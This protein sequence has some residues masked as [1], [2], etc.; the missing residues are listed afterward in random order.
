VRR[1]VVLAATGALLFGGAA[2]L[3]SPAVAATPGDQVVDAVMNGARE[4][5]PDGRRNGGDPDGRGSFTAIVSGSQLCFGITVEKLGTPVAA[6]VHKA[7]P[8]APGPVV[9]PLVAP[10]SGDPGTSSGCVTADPA[11]LANIIAHPHQYYVNVH[12]SEYPA[13]AVRGQLFHP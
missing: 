6:H 10:S 3:S 1:V 8:K 5:R 11:L 2:G 9:I 12:T 4:I 7:G 13:G